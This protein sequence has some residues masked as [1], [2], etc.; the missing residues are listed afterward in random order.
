MSKFS[1]TK[2]RIAEECKGGKKTFNEG[3]F[4]QLGTAILNDP[5]Y[6]KSELVVKKG[7]LTKT[8]TNPVKDL[9]KALIGSVAKAAGSDSAEQQKLIDEHQFPLLPVYDYV[10]STLHEYLDM[11]KRFPFARTETFQGSLEF[12]E[13]Q[14][15]VKDV[16]RPGATES[17]KQKQG[18]YTKLK[19]KSTCPD[20]LKEDL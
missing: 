7:E 1:E 6:V 12:T 14:E 3:V 11:G 17:K 8:E 5:D 20:N 18:A 16:K 15:T 9:R 13:Q 19:A 10:E 4:N 2:A